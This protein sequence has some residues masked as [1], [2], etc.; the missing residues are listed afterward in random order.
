MSSVRKK[1]NEQ[2]FTLMQFMLPEYEKNCLKEYL[3]SEDSLVFFNNKDTAIV[4]A[5]NKLKEYGAK[6]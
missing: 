3:V 6:Y 5:E 1:Y 2:A 4:E